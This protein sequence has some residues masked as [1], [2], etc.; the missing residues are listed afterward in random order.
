[1]ELK[2][3]KIV[4][5]STEGGSHIHQGVNT[6]ELFYTR[7]MVSGY[8][9]WE[10]QYLY[11]TVEDEIKNGDHF[12]RIVR[13]DTIFE[14]NNKEFISKCTNT[15][16]GNVEYSLINGSDIGRS[17]KSICKKIVTTTDKSLKID[18]N[19]GSNTSMPH[20]AS[21]PQPS[22]SFI[23]K[24]CKVGGIDEVMIEIDEAGHIKVDSRNEITIR[25]IKTS[26]TYD[27]VTHALAY[28]HGAAKDGLTHSEALVNFKAANNLPTHLVKVSRPDERELTLEEAVQEIANGGYGIMSYA[29]KKS[30][31]GG[32]QDQFAISIQD[33]MDHPVSEEEVRRIFPK[34]VLKA[35]S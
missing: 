7:D 14:P 23:E 13:G 12:I 29:A 30:V 27:D 22:K 19:R 9:S 26:F 5:V 2:R 8:K 1:M 25:P 11:F 28:G 21:F 3:S 20:I 31:E 16:D 24:Y 18:I 10:R 35:L 33:Q 15:T 6:K 34:N 4:R 32:Y 17:V